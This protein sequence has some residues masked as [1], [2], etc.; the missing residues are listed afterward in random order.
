MYNSRLLD[1]CFELTRFNKLLELENKHENLLKN[2]RITKFENMISS[3]LFKRFAQSASFLVGF[4]VLVI[5]I[6][7]VVSIKNSLKIAL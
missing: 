4:G 1:V 2:P 3:G 5:T 6:K 7:K